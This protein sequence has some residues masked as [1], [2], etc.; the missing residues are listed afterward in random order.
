MDCPSRWRRGVRPASALLLLLTLA[1]P[2]SGAALT[3]SD[4]E[5]LY[6]QGAGG[7]GF[8]LADVQ[9]IGRAPSFTANAGN[10]QY[11]AGAGSGVQIGITQ[12]L[13]T[14]HQNPGAPSFANPVIADSTWTLRNNTSTTLIAPL[15]VFTRV[16]PTGVYPITLPPT[17]LDADNLQFLTYSVSNVQYTLGAVALPTLRP[18]DTTSVLIRYVVAGALAPGDLLPR[19]GV[20]VLGTYTTVVPEPATVALVSAGLIA[21][22][23]RARARRSRG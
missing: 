1:L 13:G 22:A 7:F 17:G 9:A 23:A 3:I 10:T 12:A 8:E 15:L 18:G 19:L 5:P 20:T 11:T 16:D 21:L 4:I 14:T 6:F 2:L